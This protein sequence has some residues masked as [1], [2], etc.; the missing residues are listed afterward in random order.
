MIKIEGLSVSYTKKSAPVLHDVT[1]SV[2]EKKITV[3][4]GPNGSG[5]STLLRTICGLLR[6]Q[7]GT[8]TLDGKNLS[9]YKSHERAQKIA[10]LSQSRRIPEVT[11][12]QLVLRGRF[13]YTHFPRQYSQ[14]DYAIVEEALRALDMTALAD[15]KLHEL[16]GGQQ[17]KAWLAMALAQQTPL[18]V[19]D[20]PLTFLDIRQQL[21]LLR[22]LKTLCAQ[23][24]TILLVIHDLQTALTFADKLIV[25][26]GGRVI[27]EGEPALIAEQ[28]TID[29]AFA[30]HTKKITASDGGQF[31]TFSSEGIV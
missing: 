21:E 22:L 12:R 17:Q 9:A 26:S 14:N 4:V 28:G 6:A 16:S 8:I 1:C 11:V 3:L 10:F 25:L 27:A 19:L 29:R 20:E 13:P 5:K 2:P 31:Y 30:I 7:T 23:G 24:K 15:C 18:L